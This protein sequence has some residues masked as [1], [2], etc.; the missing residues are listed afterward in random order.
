MKISTH[1]E[2]AEAEIRRKAS[3]DAQTFAMQTT[4]AA[5]DALL[6]D[7]HRAAMYLEGRPVMSWEPSPMTCQ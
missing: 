1:A 2:V 5:R 6:L 7:S 4:R 3:E